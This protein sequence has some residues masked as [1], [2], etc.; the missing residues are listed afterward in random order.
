MSM[1]TMEEQKE[2]K[3]QRSSLSHPLAVL[4]DLGFL[5]V[6]MKVLDS[7]RSLSLLKK[8]FF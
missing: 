5:I 7:F 8:F 1:D 6:E 4:T 2:L 3:G